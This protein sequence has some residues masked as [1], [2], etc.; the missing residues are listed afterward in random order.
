MLISLEE[1]QSEY[2]INANG[3][4]HV[5]AHYGEEAAVY[6]KLWPGVKVFWVEADP[7][8]VRVLRKK[9]RG[10][11]NHVV[12]AEVVTDMIKDVE[13]NIANNGESSSM[14]EFGTH[15]KEHP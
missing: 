13:F 4:L 12:V 2:S 3:V 8:S 9:L 7:N 15:K 10:D 5:G 14:L 6:D 11:R 1:L